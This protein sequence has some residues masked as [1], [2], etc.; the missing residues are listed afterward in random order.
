MNQQFGKQAFDQAAKFL[1]DGTIQAI[2][3]KRLAASK[4]FYEKTAALATEGVKAVTEITDT[5]WGSTKILNEKVAQNVS[6]NF[7]AA[8]TAA[9]DIATAKS[10]PEMA[11]LQSEYFQKLAAQTTEQTKELVD[12]SAQATQRVFETMQAAATKPFKPVL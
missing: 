11:R 10:L 9:R 12:L 2:V 5:A 8:F 1:K 7:E 6:Q 3:D 4:D